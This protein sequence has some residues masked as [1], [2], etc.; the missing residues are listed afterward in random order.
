[1]E[2]HK[3]FAIK[4]VAW[5]DDIESKRPLSTRELEDRVAAMEEFKKWALMEK[6]S[7]KQKSRNLA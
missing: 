6:I 5:W 4:K 7:W 1:M 3:K 2:E